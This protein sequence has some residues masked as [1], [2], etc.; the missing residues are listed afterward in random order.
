L[1]NNKSKGL[2]AL[3]SIKTSDGLDDAERAAEFLFKAANVMPERPVPATHIVQR[4]LALPTLP[5]E[6]SSRVSDFKKRRMG[7]VRK[8]IFEKY[9]RALLSMPGF[10]Y[11][12]TT[13]S[14]DTAVTYQE[15]A[16]RGLLSAADR[17]DRVRS[18]IK[19][20]ELRKSTRERFDEVGDG[21]KRL[22]A[23]LKKLRAPEEEEAE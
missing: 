9:K 11:R 12:C 2:T 17:V 7:R 15:K 19:P 23:P 13:G 21:L 3:K 18:I 6:D 22:Q 10:G 16:V 1:T 20:S 4:A 8:I 14:E 5:K